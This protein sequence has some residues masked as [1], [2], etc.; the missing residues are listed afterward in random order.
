MEIT[1]RSAAGARYE[2]NGDDAR[3]SRTQKAGANSWYTRGHAEEAMGENVVEGIPRLVG[4][5]RV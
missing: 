1:V 2:E 5:R 3:E 4:T